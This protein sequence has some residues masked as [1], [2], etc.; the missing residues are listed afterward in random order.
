[1]IIMTQYYIFLE[2][3][4]QLKAREDGIVKLWG[5]G[6]FYQ[7]LYDIAIEDFIAWHIF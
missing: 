2:I 1:M 3:E 7:G 6:V 5:R 4:D